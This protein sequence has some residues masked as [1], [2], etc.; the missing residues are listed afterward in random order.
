VFKP[1]AIGAAGGQE[2]GPLGRPTP[3]V[4]DAVGRIEDAVAVVAE[5]NEPVVAVREKIAGENR[6]PPCQGPPTGSDLVAVDRDLSELVE[7]RGVEAGTT[8]D[9]RCRKGPRG[10]RDTFGDELVERPSECVDRDR[11]PRLGRVALRLKSRQPEKLCRRRVD[12]LSEVRRQQERGETGIEE[13]LD[14]GRRDTLQRTDVIGLLDHFNPGI[15]PDGPGPLG[16]VVVVPRNVVVIV[17]FGESLCLEPAAHFGRQKGPVGETFRRG[18]CGESATHVGTLNRKPEDSQ[19]STGIGPLGG[20]EV[21]NLGAVELEASGRRQPLAG[22]APAF[23]AEGERDVH[24]V[25]GGHSPPARAVDRVGAR[26]CDDSR[27]HHNR[28]P[29]VADDVDDKRD[30]DDRHNRSEYG[31]GQPGLEVHAEIVPRRR[32]SIIRLEAE[33]MI[34]RV[35]R[36]A[37][38]LGIGEAGVK[39]GLLAVAV[40]IARGAGPAAVGT[41]S[42]AFAAALI[43]VMVLASGQQEVLIRE[44]ARAPERARTL[45][46]LSNTLQRRVAVWLVPVAGAVAFLVSDRDLRL[47]LLSF[48]PYVVLRTATVT[49]GAAFK[50]LDRM[51]VEVRARGL[52]ILVAVV[53][54]GLGVILAWP[55]WTA[56]VAFSVGAAL[57]LAWIAHMSTGLGFEPPSGSGASAL[58]EG[59]PFMV[60]AVL[61]QLLTNADRFLLA[62][63]G[64]ARTEIGY[65]GAAAT[66]VWAL[67][68]APQLVAVAVYPTFSRLAHRGDTWRRAGLVSV[69]AG[70]AAGVVCALTLREIAGPLV[71]LFF[72]SDFEPAVQLMSRLSLVLPGAFAMM[73]VGT[74]Y[75]A[76]RRQLLAMWVLAATFAVS[77]TLN[78]AWIPGSGPIACADAAVVSYSA[79]AA[80]MALSLFAAAGPRRAAS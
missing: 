40:L 32:W 69:A 3:G 55:V 2:R 76:W 68:A 19:R 58:R 34:T 13:P 8:A 47:S 61:S 44:V 48:V 70:G 25:A 60:L 80:A 41:F 38:W 30:G 75:A 78:L 50:G 33:R 39:G 65:W 73:I 45:L 18:L 29:A 26:R 5:Q 36:N 43:G 12:V 49:R 1:G 42:I 27:L 79:G 66:I 22:T 71:Q 11:V 37:I 9:G 24:L 63:F 17:D 46:V 6:V 56:G 72:G 67:V 15:Q 14:V 77:L 62:M 57:G 4:K 10:N 21:G 53:G 52:E 31:D 54:V 20:L 28:L 51:D 74:V 23:E 59:L 7:G 35:L 64:V 16:G